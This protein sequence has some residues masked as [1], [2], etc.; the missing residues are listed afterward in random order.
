MSLCVHTILSDTQAEGPGHRF[1]I[2]VQGCDIRCPGCVATHTWDAADGRAMDVKD[3]LA[4]LDERLAQDPPLEGVTFLGGEPFL[5][6]EPLARIA[7]HAREEN[8]SVFC[9]SGHTLEELKA[10]DN[11]GVAEL[12][13]LVDVLADG[14]YVEGL[15]DFSRPWVG[16]SNQRFHFL[17]GRY[18][19]DAFLGTGNRVEVRIRPNGAVQ[20]NGMAEF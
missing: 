3:V 17:T 6:A 10:S 7:R 12:L 19:P 15:R 4:L 5:Q 14:P 8:L 20:I 16:S 18:R 9:F 11:P 13:S 1:C 2:W